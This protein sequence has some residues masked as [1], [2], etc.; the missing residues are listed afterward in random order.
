MDNDSLIAVAEDIQYLG[1]WGSDISNA[2]IRRGTAI[3]RR[4]LVEDAYGAAW[5]AVGE[6]KQP[7][8]IAVDLSLMLGEQANDAVYAL[9]GGALF[10]G[11]Y[12]ACSLLNKGSKPIGGSPPPAIRENG[13]PFERFFTLSEYLSSPSG[14]V[15]GRSFNRREVIKYIANIKGGVH[16]SAQQR[17]QEEKLIAR[18]GKIEKKIMVH[19]TDG[20]LVEAVAIAQ[21]LGTSDDA[22]K[23][24]NKVGGSVH[25]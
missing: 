21:A 25:A 15:E 5:R 9:A 6:E 22:K 14:V 13:Y 23:F 2:E 16:L 18:L 12:M 4:L 10:R 11:M 7:S 17:K 20:L 24:I 8:L 19:N 3:L 1:T